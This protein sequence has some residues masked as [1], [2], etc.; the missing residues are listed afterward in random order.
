MKKLTLLILA[1][2][3]ASRY[4]SMKQIDGFG[5]NGETIIDYSIYD[6]IEAGFGKIT[7]VI[8][9]EFLHSFK[10][11]FN[12]RLAGKVET[13]Y[14]FQTV[15]LQKY[16]IDKNIE[17]TKPWGTAHAVLEAKNQIHEPF[18]VI[19]ADDFYGRDAFKITANFLNNE[20]AKN[21]YGVVGYK[22]GNTLSA[23][24]PVSRAVFKTDAN[25]N[26]AEI[27]ER[28]KVYSTKGEI[29]YE[30]NEI[31]NPLD[32]SDLVSMNFWA[33]TP[34]VFEATEKLFVDF[35]SKN[36]ND[37]SAE[38]YIP[39]VANYLIENDIANFKAIPTDAK[40]FGVTYK[41]DKKIVQENIETL[42]RDGAYPSQLWDK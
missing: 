38:F 17:R 7:F 16:G 32:A 37:P 11:T 9:E 20:A 39:F 23:N 3:M 2:G 18:C 34:D 28:T 15:D 4:G 26:I 21:R 35:V 40:W 24:G 5:S 19:N 30:E 33:F 13:D 42:V 29:I 27:T 22:V 10:S 6:A 31:E 41:T 25:G 1:A 36:A 8:R 12:K 14:V